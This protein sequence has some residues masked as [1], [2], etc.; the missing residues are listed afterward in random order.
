MGLDAGPL[1]DLLPA[2]LGAKSRFTLTVDSLDGVTVGEQQRHIYL[3]ATPTVAGIDLREIGF[4]LAE[5]DPAIEL[6]T[7][8]GMSLDA[9]V[10]VA[11]D[12]A[13]FAM[14]L[15]AESDAPIQ[16]TRIDP[17][18]LTIK[19][20][21]GLVRG[22]GYLAEHDGSFA[23]TLELAIGPTSAKAV[24]LLSTDPFSLV[25]LFFA[26]FSTAIQLSFGF[27]LNGIGGLLAVDRSLSREALQVR[28][29]D[30]TADALLFPDSRD[31]ANQELLESVFPPRSGAVAVGPA[32]KLG[33]G[34]P[35]SLMVAKVGVM[36]VLPDPSVVVIG[37]LRV[38]I[39]SPALPIVD[40]NVGV[41]GEITPDHVLVI[42]GL[43]GSRM[44][45]FTL[46]GDFGLLIGYGARPIFALSAGGFH[47]RFSPPGALAKLRRITVDMSPPIL[48]TLR[49]D[50]YVALTSSAFM[51]GA[52]VEAGIDF[53]VAS[54]HG[55]LAFD[56]IVLWN[57]VHFEIDLRAL[58]EVEVGGV[59][60]LGVGVALHLEGPGA[61]VAH[62]TA[63]IDFF[64]M[65]TL[66]LEVGPLTW[67]ERRVQQQIT[68]SPAALVLEQLRDRAS[69]Q[70][71]LPRGAERLI[72]FS[73]Q[74]SQDA[75]ALLAHPLG[76]FEVRQKLLPLDTELQHHGGYLVSEH[77]ITL[78]PP[79]VGG[80]Q[81]ASVAVVK[82]LFGTG[83]FRELRDDEKLSE[84]EF[85]S[86]PSGVNLAASPT[87]FGAVVGSELGWRTV[88][89][90]QQLDEAAPQSFPLDIQLIPHLLATSA[91]GRCRAQADGNPYQRLGAR[92][93]GHG[94]A[95]VA[96]AP[97]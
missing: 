94:P 69:W 20:D 88:Y 45:G 36:L 96:G 33:W 70:P 49:A 78:G 21:A 86:L 65:P 58:V 15:D 46:S 83:Q 28:I 5:H 30:G 32:F 87:S 35:I 97:R 73:D 80:T 93:R 92:V 50:A 57:P 51:V 74:P 13:G 9:G 31:Q 17:A 79:Q 54:A 14:A 52:R 40:L 26:E 81:A 75:T 48:L 1:V 6:T 12:G 63:S 71:Q 8:F 60:V 3:P 24:V 91:A 34:T 85:E 7:Q 76:G 44:A 62:G 67:G 66:H 39:P 61:W 2:G 64:F 59:T 10:A 4:G 95:L 23:G 19:I 11:I 56:A 89:P 38:A 53:G 42:A 16:I 77:R 25:V 82:D 72:S 84:A 41:Y 68:V 55:Q 90:G 22:G 18:G 27:T 29:W 37:K 47:P 43:A